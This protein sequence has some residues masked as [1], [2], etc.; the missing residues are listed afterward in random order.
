MFCISMYEVYFWFW[1]YMQIKG[2]ISD[3]EI[4]FFDE[5]KFQSI[6]FV[7]FIKVMKFVYLK[8]N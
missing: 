3:Y 6:K 2:F 1:K 5:M 4:Y 8:L 7:D